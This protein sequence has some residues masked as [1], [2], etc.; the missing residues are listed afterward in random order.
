[1]CQ[2]SKG[3][4]RKQL[5]AKGAFSKIRLNNWYLCKF[6]ILPLLSN[7]SNPSRKISA[8]AKIDHIKVCIM[9]TGVPICKIENINKSLILFVF[10]TIK[11]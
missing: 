2:V 3:D 4:D 6:P 11:I 1:M 9:A 7:T 10:V 8:I 5:S